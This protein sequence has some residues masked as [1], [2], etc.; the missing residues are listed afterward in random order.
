[1]HI[2]RAVHD[3][4]RIRGAGQGGEVGGGEPEGRDG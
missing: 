1:M 3:Y 2:G 4:T